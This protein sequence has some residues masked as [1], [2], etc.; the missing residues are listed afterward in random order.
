MFSP[1]TNELPIR[2]AL[3]VPANRPGRIDKAVEA[4]A[5]AVII[6]LEDAVPPDQKSA[7]RDNAREALERHKGKPVD[8]LKPTSIRQLVDRWP[9]ESTIIWCKYNHEQELIAR[10]FPEAAS[11]DGKTP[12]VKRM[13]MIRD[14]KA[15][16][17][18]I[19]ISKPKILG[20]GLNLQ[21]ATRQVFSAL[22]DSYESFYQAVKRS[23][24]VGST[25]PLHVHL[26]MTD[27]ERIQIENVLRKKDRV[28]A[29][30]A[31]QERIFKEMAS[32]NV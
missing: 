29:D 2:S 25:R 15:G 4:G 32:W 10:T 17:C 11:M 31:E 30:T 23:N 14:F 28:Q 1:N 27:L 16:R 5:D 21:R 12:H 20:F 24:R 26:P 6:D 13:E 19:L 8:T 22:E 18:K 9:D 3:F 7:A